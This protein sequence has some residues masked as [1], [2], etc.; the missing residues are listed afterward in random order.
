V[1]PVPADPNC[2]WH[3]ASVNCCHF[4]PSG[5]ASA[6]CR[7]SQA[8]GQPPHRV[9]L[10]TGCYL[11]IWPG[12]ASIANKYTGSKILPTSFCAIDQQG[13]RNGSERDRSRQQAQPQE[14][15]H[16]QGRR[17]RIS[18]ARELTGGPEWREPPNSVTKNCRQCLRRRNDT[19]LVKTVRRSR[20][21]RTDEHEER[22]A[23]RLKRR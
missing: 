7:T 9:P 8:S 4:A 11:N 13:P 2:G 12:L 5:M 16:I 19:P 18:G 3:S 14:S 17:Q 10:P 15:N 23:L 22:I 1:L 21:R 6:F 20:R